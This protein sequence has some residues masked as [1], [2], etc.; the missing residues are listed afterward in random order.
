MYL[1]HH[2][3][4]K[5]ANKKNKQINIQPNDQLATGF[6]HCAFGRIAVS[7]VTTGQ[8]DHPQDNGRQN[9]PAGGN[10]RQPNT[11][12]HNSNVIVISMDRV[13]PSRDDDAMLPALKKG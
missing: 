10:T 1:V 13:L 2:H 5:K 6:P 3:I 12:P 9:H 4:P 8:L 11:N 7:Y